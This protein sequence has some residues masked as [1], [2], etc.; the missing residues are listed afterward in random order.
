MYKKVIYQAY[1]L[2]FADANGD[3]LGDV[4]GIIDKLDYLHSLGVDVL[5]IN[6]I[7]VSPKNDNGYDIVDY[8]AIDHVF[9]TMAEVEELIQKAKTYQI[10]IMFD[11]VL[12]H[13]SIFHPWFQKALA[14]DKKYQDFYFFRKGDVD[15]A[16][17]NWVSKFGGSAWNWNEKIQM[18]NLALFDK[19]QADLNWD[20]PAVRDEIYKIVNFWISKGIKGFRFD[21]INLISKPK[22]FENADLSVHDGRLF[23]T[24]GPNIHKYLHLLNHNTFGKHHGITTVGEMS[25]TKL[26]AALKYANP[27]NQ[28]LEM[29]FIFHHLKVD[30]LNGNKW[31][32]KS[33]DKKEFKKLLI[34]WQKQMCAHKSHMA[35]FLNNHDQPRVNSRWGDIKNHWY[36]SSTL[37]TALN[38][39]L[40]GTPFI[41]Q[42][43]EIG[44]TN[45][46]FN[47]IEDYKDVESIN[48]YKTLLVQGNSVAEALKVLAHISR[49]NSR[50]PMQ[51]DESSY[52]GFSK[53][54]PW[55][56]INSNYTKINVA[57]QI[58]DPTSILNFYKKMIH[59]R[60]TQDALSSDEIEFIDSN[61]NTFIFKRSYKD[62]EIMCYF[63][64]SNQKENIS[65]YLQDKKAYK[66]L[67]NNYN[68]EFIDLVLKPFELLILERKK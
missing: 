17:T 4:R 34:E 14:G 30:Y 66:I 47:D 15:Q 11:M 67:L 37:F 59:L 21:V 45:H 62:Q 36:A 60:K 19:T 58:N 23:Y 53:V 51:W 2:S 68:K 46:D 10:D 52:A 1:P 56:K 40:V 38:F 25:S 54:N 16:P 42:G 6:P 28:E 8:L 44:M 35:L 55:I 65:Q 3:G 57:S 50:T 20:N 26:E 29:V 7:F 22:V 27:K 61:E 39:F 41:Y 63:N 49:D 32:H 5:W 13:S 64:W 48:A 9:G 24:D 33:W 12:N 18:W 31:V 43:E